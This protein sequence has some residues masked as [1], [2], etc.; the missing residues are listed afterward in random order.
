MRLYLPA[1]DRYIVFERIGGIAGWNVHESTGKSIDPRQ[2]EMHELIAVGR[3]IEINR[4]LQ[5]GLLEEVDPYMLSP[6]KKP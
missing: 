1:S 5:H 2:L 4:Q 6:W 3:A